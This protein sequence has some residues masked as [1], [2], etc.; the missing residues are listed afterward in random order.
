MNRQDMITAAYYFPNFHVDP[1]NEE[2]HGEGWT[3]W[4]LMKHATPRFP[5]HLQPRVPLHGYEDES[6]P[7][8]MAGKIDM[9]A[10]AGLDAFLFDWYWYDSRPY[11]QRPLEEAFLP[12]SAGGDVRFAL[13]WANHDWLNIHPWKR[14]TQPTTLAA[15]PVDGNE[16]RR[17]TDYMIERYFRHPQYLR[18]NDRPYLSIYELGTL[19]RGLGGL[20][21]TA[22]ALQDLRRRVKS[23]GFP[24]IH[25]NVV[26]LEIPVLPQEQPNNDLPAVLP[27]LG[28]DSVTS[29]VWIHHHRLPTLCTPYSDVL[30]QAVEAWPRFAQQYSVPYFPNVTVGWDSS[31]RT[32]QSDVFDPRAGYPHTNIIV[33]NTPAQ[34]GRALEEARSFLE[35]SG[36][37]MLT[38][39]A[40]NEWTEGSYLEPDTLNGTGYLDQLQRVFG[41]ERTS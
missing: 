2:W 14:G 33:D 17:A 27:I 37:T 41:P 19:V 31:P 7:D 28:F 5:G 26:G 12:T 6:D 4:E 8:V 25:L 34:F 35:R 16:F 40:W 29:Y 9:A 24:D 10:R 36:A 11:L 15:G 38:I 3:E 23:A 32:V 30:E 22:E 20:E 18:I 1:R 39:N 13:M 21:A